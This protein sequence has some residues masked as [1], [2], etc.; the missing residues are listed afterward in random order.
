MADIRYRIREFNE[1]VTLLIYRQ[2]EYKEQEKILLEDIHLANVPQA[3]EF[4]GKNYPQA[5][6]D[7]H[8]GTL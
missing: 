7:F 4:I 3:L 2:D 1:D 8:E 5:H 6:E